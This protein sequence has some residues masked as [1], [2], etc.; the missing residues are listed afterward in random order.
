MD[1]FKCVSSVILLATLFSG[2]VFG[3]EPPAPEKLDAKALA[4]VQSSIDF[5]KSVSS[6]TTT[7]SNQ[8]TLDGGPNKKKESSGAYEI[9]VELPNKLALVIKEGELRCAVYSDGK[10]LT[11][12]A[13][14][15][16]AYTQRDAP[17]TLPEVFDVEEISSIVQEDLNNVFFL[18]TLTNDHALDSVMAGVTALRL[19]GVE[20]LD[21]GGM[22][23][24][25]HFVESK[26]E[27]DMWV[28]EGA[29]PLLR[30]I[31]LSH[32][33]T[34]RDKTGPV[35]VKRT[36]VSRYDNWTVNNAIPPERFVYVPAP[37]F[38]RVPS[39][40]ERQDEAGATHEAKLLG[41]P[42]PLFSA[43]LLSGGVLDLASHKD[44][45]VVVLDFWASWVGPSQKTMPIIAEVC[46]GFKD[47][48]LAAYEVNLN[49]TP[50]KIK[51]F[52]STAGWL[53]LPIV[54]D[55]EGKL[56]DTYRVKA[57]PMTVLIGKSGLVE[58]VYAH[59]PKDLPAFKIQLKTEIE[60]LLSGGTLLKK[61]S[62]PAK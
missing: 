5:L 23:Y 51:E 15:L 10:T 59:A 1:F 22:A 57:L 7:L 54:V 3:A 27:W 12:V 61:E 58:A 52:Q 38:R 49:E 17:K 8:S 24:H 53:T 41:K 20:K 6:Y 13:P 50:D 30:K 47:R 35:K 2:G 11:A 36:V 48:G 56:T 45:N 16:K 55:Q 42:A 18:N 4:I 60:T 33:G 26:V 34:V 44:K 31:V 14:Q 62:D 46:A 21:G 40:L 28:Q 25:L 43:K 39:F 32:D 29:Q 19:F 37:E 9:A